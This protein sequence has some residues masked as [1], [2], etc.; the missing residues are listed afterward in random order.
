M[1]Y[2]AAAK[3]LPITCAPKYNHIKF[4]RHPKAK[5]GPKKRAG[6]YAPP[7][8]LPLVLI[9]IVTDNPIAIGAIFPKPGFAIAV[10]KTVLE[11]INIPIHSQVNILKYISG[12]L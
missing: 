5:A 7:V 4:R 2:D 6:L 3:R 1:Q 12:P 9:L 8:M 11:R 10:A